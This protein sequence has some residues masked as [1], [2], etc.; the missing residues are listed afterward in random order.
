MGDLELMLGKIVEDIK[1]S[2]GPEM[3]FD[4]AVIVV[5]VQDYRAT[6]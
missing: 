4:A 3:S 1:S 2:I 5:K 6:A